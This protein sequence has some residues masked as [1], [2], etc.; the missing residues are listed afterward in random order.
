MDKFS[1][2]VLITLLAVLLI[3]W[4]GEFWASLALLAGLEM[5]IIAES[6]ED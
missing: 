6:T 4:A 2:V 5:G 1:I 3:M